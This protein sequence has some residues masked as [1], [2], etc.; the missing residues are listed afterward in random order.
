MKTAKDLF[1][2]LGYERE[3]YANQIIYKNHRQFIN[4]DKNCFIVFMNGINPYQGFQFYT[5]SLMEAID[6]QLSELHWK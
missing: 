6:R 1:E 3:E 2:K 4:F 5:Y